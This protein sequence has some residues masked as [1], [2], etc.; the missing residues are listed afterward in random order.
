M[1]SSEE[2]WEGRCSDLWT[3]GVQKSETFLG[4]L[5][6]WH[7]HPAHHHHRN[8][9]Q[10]ESLNRRRRSRNVEGDDEGEEGH[11]AK[12]FSRLSDTSG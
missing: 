11:A 1:K 3:R 7:Q 12:R 6:E 10:T 9:L 8:V 2:T 5:C 4:I